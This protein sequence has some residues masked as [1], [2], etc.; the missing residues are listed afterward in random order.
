MVVFLFSSHHPGY[1]PAVPS[2]G[3]DGKKESEKTREREKDRE[4]EFKIELERGR[5][6]GID[7]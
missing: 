1:V 4:R 7:R 2:S 6:G 5:E 3:S